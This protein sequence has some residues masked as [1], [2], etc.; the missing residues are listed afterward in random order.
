MRTDVDWSKHELL[1]TENE[2][3]TIH[4]LKKPNTIC[5]SVKFINVEGIL[6]VTGDY[7]NWLFCRSFL[8]T[9]DGRVSDHYW[10]EKLRIAS[11]QNGE[12]FSSELTKK[13]IE[14]HLAELKEED[15]KPEI[16]E[17]IKEYYTEC[18]NVVEDG[19]WVYSAYA[20][21]NFP[22]FWDHECVPFRKRIK[23]H[24]QVVFDAFEEICKRLKAQENGKKDNQ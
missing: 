15:W 22:S 1:I 9:P 10:L 6:T 24:L 13:E 20:Y 19:E 17:E 12:E 4:H 11:T 21:Q 8:P 16:L 3:V 2:H 14:Q 23:P 5:D 7:S 18:L